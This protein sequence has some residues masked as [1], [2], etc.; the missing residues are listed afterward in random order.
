M[1]DGTTTPGERG[2]DTPDEEREV[3]DR[4]SQE[5]PVTKFEE[6]NAEEE[7][8]RRLQAERAADDPLLDD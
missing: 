6:R 8:L 1:E 5:S 3:R 2:A 4:E 7:Q